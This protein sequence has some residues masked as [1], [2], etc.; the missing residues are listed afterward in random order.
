MYFQ[1]I[2]LLWMDKGIFICNSDAAW[3]WQE[4]N[5]KELVKVSSF[6]VFFLMWTAQQPRTA[7]WRSH[8][9]RLELLRGKELSAK[10]KKS[11]TA[12]TSHLGVGTEDAFG[13]AHLADVSD[14][15]NIHARERVAWTHPIR[16]GEGLNETWWKTW[17]WWWIWATV[18]DLRDGREFFGRERVWWAVSCPVW[19]WE[20]SEI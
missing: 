8:V 7:W 9:W 16:A 14:E 3:G 2:M 13:R 18:T 10:K 19:N 17:L 1:S 6:E 11:R 4:S 15:G 20:K 12:K 5:E